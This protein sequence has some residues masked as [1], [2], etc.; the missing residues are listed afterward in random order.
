MAE[1]A[2]TPEIVTLLGCCL[3]ILFP[4]LFLFFLIMALT[5]KSKGWIIAAVVSGILALLL[6]GVLM[7]GGAMSA[8]KGIKEA[9]EPREFTSRDELVQITGGG[10]WRIQD[11]G[12]EDATLAV[13]SP[14]KEEY[15]IVIS[16][17]KADF[18]EGF[19]LSQFAQVALEQSSAAITD[20]EAGEFTPVSVNG[21]DGLRV[22]ITGTVDGI[23][24]AYLNTYLSGRDHFHQVMSWTLRERR[25]TAFPNLKSASDSF[26]ET[27]PGNQ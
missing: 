15:L 5:R 6:F 13:G 2:G 1:S 21:L 23:G 12:V 26:R 18:P 9:A 20:P 17:P 11:L 27:E 8:F 19:D 14:F 10:G 16:E 22:E 3:G 25:E 7:L 24:I 4:A